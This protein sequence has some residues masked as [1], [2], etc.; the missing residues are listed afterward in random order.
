MT[1]WVQGFLGGSDTKESACN[2]GDLGSIPELGRSPREENGSPLKYS[3]LKNSMDRGARQVTVHRVTKVEYN[4]VTKH[5]QYEYKFSYERSYWYRNGKSQHILKCWLML[6][7]PKKKKKNPHT[8]KILFSSIF[9]RNILW[10][11]LHIRRI[12][13][14]I[15]CKA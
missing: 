14:N 9:W 10:I 12:F 5:T 13:Y 7:T 3:H 1:V 11:P 2:V 15:F 6:K 4:R 8:I